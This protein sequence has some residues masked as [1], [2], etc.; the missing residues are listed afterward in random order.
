LFSESLP[1]VII[2]GLQRYNY[3]DSLILSLNANALVYLPIK[4]YTDLSLPENYKT[5]LYTFAF[6]YCKAKAKEKGG[7]YGII[8]TSP[9]FVSLTLASKRRPGKGCEA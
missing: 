9:D 4:I 2:Q 5:D 8:N 1:C 6:D 3:E 7:V